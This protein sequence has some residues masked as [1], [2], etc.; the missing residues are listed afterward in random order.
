MKVEAGRFERRLGALE[1]HSDF[2]TGGFRAVMSLG[3]AGNMGLGSPES[4][5]NRGEFLNSLGVEGSRVLS[6]PLRHSRKVWT[7]RDS[8]G[9]KRFEEFVE[10]DGGADGIV[11]AGRIWIG[12]VTVADC[13]PIWLLDRKTGSF[14]ILH[15]GWKG[16]GIL[17]SGI[18]SMAKAFG[19]IPEDLTVVLGPSIGSCCYRISAERAEG[20]RA[21][22]GPESTEQ[23]QIEREAAWFLDLGGAN[24]GIAGRMDVA[25][26]VDARICTACSPEFGSFRREGEGFTRMLALAGYF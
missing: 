4:P 8:E 16:T 25:V 10:K 23:R 1:I 14:G 21:E 26:L 18:N 20:F 7:L 3:Q 15:S 17:E 6:L 9:R 22:F 2:L 5:A 24:R 12:S 11:L 13:M 19:T